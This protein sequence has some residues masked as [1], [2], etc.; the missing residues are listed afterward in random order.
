[1]ADA[2]IGLILSNMPP[3]ESARLLINLAN[4]RGGFD[5]STVIVVNVESYPAPDTTQTPASPIPTT[6]SSA[7][8]PRKSL[9]RNAATVAVL[10]LAASLAFLTAQ[11]TVARLPPGPGGFLVATVA[12]ALTLFLGLLLALRIHRSGSTPAPAAPFTTAAVTVPPLAHPATATTGPAT[13]GPLPAPEDFPGTSS[14]Q[15]LLRSSFNSQAPY[16]TVPCLKADELFSFLAEAHAE[17][18]QAS[19]DNSWNVDLE[20]LAQLDRQ[21]TAAAQAGKLDRALRA[22]GRAIDLVM[23]EIP[24][25]QTP[26][27]NV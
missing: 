6:A 16:R 26:K 12:G 3:S 7:P 22:R 1:V 19:R 14:D 15:H 27:G 10:L 20:E 11:L 17:L 18:I 8:R 4:L 9:A 2:E 5:N 13:T 25:K 24:Q 23:R 21:A